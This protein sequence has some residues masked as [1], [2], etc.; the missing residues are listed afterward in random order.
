MFSTIA[1]PSHARTPRISSAPLGMAGKQDGSAVQAISPPMIA[2]RSSTPDPLR[3]LRTG[4]ARRLYAKSSQLLAGSED[5][6]VDA[7]KD[8]QAKESK[9][10]SLVGRAADQSTTS[11]GTTLEVMASPSLAIQ[12]INVLPGF[13]DI[14]ERY[15]PLS[16]K[17]KEC[18][19]FNQFEFPRVDKRFM[20]F[21]QYHLGY[22]LDQNVGE[23]RPK[24]MYDEAI[25]GQPKFD[26]RIEHP[27]RFGL[28]V[29]KLAKQHKLVRDPVVVGGLLLRLLEQNLFV[30]V[31]SVITTRSFADLLAYID[32]A[33][34]N[35]E[36]LATR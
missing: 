29:L 30:D 19:V 22:V 18:I 12:S 8:V 2:D 36:A 16:T 26:P 25:F 13:E 4:A 21:V 5:E 17:Y 34:R 31:T 14:D 3:L 32:E 1:A 9:I 28:R 7:A 33:C 35:E 27:R 23:N 6:P 15:V 11:A 24:N 20:D 10:E